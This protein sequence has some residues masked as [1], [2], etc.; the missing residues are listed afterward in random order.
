M[1][2]IIIESLQ[3]CY[4]HVKFNIKFIM[5]VINFKPILLF[6]HDLYFD[7]SQYTRKLMGKCECS[8]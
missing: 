2:V 1:C 6:K 8:T 7:A 3:A 4:G 5:S